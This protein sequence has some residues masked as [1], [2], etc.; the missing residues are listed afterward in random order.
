[1]IAETFGQITPKPARPRHPQQRI[2]ERPVVAAQ[3]ALT[4]PAAQ[5]HVP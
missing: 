5:H 1:M 3:T 4:R 2:D